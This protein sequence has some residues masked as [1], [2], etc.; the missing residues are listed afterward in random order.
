MALGFL[1]ALRNNIMDEVTALV[2]AGAGAG[3]LRIYDG[4]QPATGGT[5]TTLLAELTLSDPS[6]GAAV[7]AAI[8]ANAITGDTSADNTGT[9]T[10]FRIVDSNIVFV[11][12]GT[13]GLVASG[14][15]LELNTVAI[16]AGVAVDISSMVLTAGNA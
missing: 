3:L 12:D 5:V 11:L 1:E 9:A 2:D 10:W 4:T 16:T 14:A 6:F 13:V 7:S 15:D 8:T